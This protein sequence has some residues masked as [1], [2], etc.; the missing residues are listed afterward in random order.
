MSPVR[1]MK[2]EEVTVRYDRLNEGC[3]EGGDVDT[4]RVGIWSVECV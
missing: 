1:G 3:V 4:C 2:G